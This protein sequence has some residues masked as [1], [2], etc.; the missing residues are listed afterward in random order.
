MKM[1]IRPSANTD[2][3]HDIPVIFLKSIFSRL[4]YERSWLLE[5]HTPLSL[6]Y[7]AYSKVLSILQPTAFPSSQ[8]FLKSEAADSR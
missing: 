1:L 5:A 7:M 4:G 3:A 8:A 2:W 6:R